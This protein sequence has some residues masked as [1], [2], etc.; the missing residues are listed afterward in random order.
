MLSHTPRLSKVGLHSVLTSSRSVACLP[1]Q[2]LNGMDTEDFLS[3][4]LGEEVMA[5]TSSCLSHSPR[6]SD[7]GISDDSGGGAANFHC[8]SPQSS[9]TELAHSPVGMDSSPEGLP[10]GPEVLA[11]QSDHS[12]SLLQNDGNAL[13]SVR[14]E[15]PDCDVFIDL[16]KAKE[17][18]LAR[19]VSL[20]S[21]FDLGCNM[22]F[23]L[24]ICIFFFPDDLEET[25]ME[26]CSD[27]LPCSLTIE[28]S[29]H[30]NNTPE[31][32]Y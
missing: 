16:G 31:Q 29:V 4:L 27:E 30:Q 17:N 26:D 2:V 14:S 11:I 24:F 7:S 23:Y 32:V 1:F 20:V 19:I 5:D 8:Q 28:D 10:E 13:E 12:Y 25:M 6:G 21:V 18:C 9:D 15:R 3:S 22:N